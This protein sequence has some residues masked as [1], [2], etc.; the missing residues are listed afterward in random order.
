[1]LDGALECVRAGHIPGGLNA[2]REFAE[3]VIGYEDDVPADIKTLLFDPQTAGGLL[4]AVNPEAVGHLTES[5]HAAGI[6]AAKIGAIQPAGK[7]LV[8]VKR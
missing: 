2:N 6:P 4:I 1:L 7:P 3:C 5:L 8:S